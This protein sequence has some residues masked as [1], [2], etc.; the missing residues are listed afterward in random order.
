MNIPYPL[1]EH[2]GEVKDQ[3][4][5]EIWVRGGDHASDVAD[6]IVNT[7]ARFGHANVAAIGAHAVNQAVKGFAVSRNLWR[8]LK[9]DEDLYMTS[10]FSTFVDAQDKE[11]TRMKFAIFSQRDCVHS[12]RW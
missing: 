10:W 12:L 2:E 6:Q 4:E 3:P 1:A 7:I 8:N 11:R 5:G 9:E